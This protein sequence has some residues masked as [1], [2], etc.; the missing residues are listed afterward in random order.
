MMQVPAVNS[1]VRVRVRNTDSHLYIPP[2]PEYSLYEGT[3]VKP[4][5]W[6]SVTEIAL[7]NTNPNFPVR[8][9]NIAHA[10]SVDLVE[11]KLNTVNDH[12]RSITV[13]GSR[14]KQYTVTRSG[15]RITCTCEGF[16]FRKSCK[17]LKLI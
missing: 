2:R 15:T 4:Y 17:H 12:D 10:D 1:R 11:G 14:G 5:P 3:V 6:L 8:V 7:T 13:D 16:T 9:I